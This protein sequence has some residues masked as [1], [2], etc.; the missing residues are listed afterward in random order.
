MRG[1]CKPGMKPVAVTKADNGKTIQ[2][3]LGSTVVVTLEGNPGST[4]Y[5]WGL[6][7]GN[8]AV[9]KPQG[10]FTFTAST[11]NLIGAPGKFE[12]KFTAASAGSAT[13]KFANKRP[14]ELNDPKAETF[15][16]TVNVK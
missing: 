1:E 16:V 14:W 6:E 13:L 3:A 4:G 10:D 8:D 9:L 7:S 5:L 12:F 11:S 2:A 15:S